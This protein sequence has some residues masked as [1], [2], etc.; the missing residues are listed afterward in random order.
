MKRLTFETVRLKLRDELY[1][2]VT[3]NLRR[4]VLSA[5]DF[6]IISNNCWAGTVYESYGLRKATPTAG[7]FIM[8]EDYLTLVSNLERELSR[9]LVFIRPEESKWRSELEHSSDWGEYL[10]GRIGEIELHMLHYHDESVARKKWEARL[11]RVN[12]RKLI[13]KFNDQNGCTEDQARRFD[14]L[15]LEHK[16]FLTVRDYPGVACAIR[17]GGPR[18]GNYVRAS[19]EPFGASRLFNVN[20]YLNSRFSDASGRAN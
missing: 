13:F 5:T 1:I 11:E 4:R 15:D 20:R 2:P 8:P 6:T 18:K 3:H 14:E 12:Y 19:R 9:P 17:V 10:I 16:I 7:M